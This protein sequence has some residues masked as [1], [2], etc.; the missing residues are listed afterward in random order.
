MQRML[1]DDDKMEDFS[2]RTSIPQIKTSRDVLYF[3]KRRFVEEEGQRRSSKKARSS[4][5]KLEKSVL[6]S[7]ESPLVKKIMT[8]RRKMSG[9]Q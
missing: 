2:A 3:Q 6:G 5:E 4:R 7:L 1:L 8:M 9:Q